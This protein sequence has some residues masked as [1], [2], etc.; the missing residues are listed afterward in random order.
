M[1]QMAN[2]L[3]ATT[4]WSHRVTVFLVAWFLYWSIFIYM[5]NDTKQQATKVQTLSFEWSNFYPSF[6]NGGCW[7]VS[8]VTSCRCDDRCCSLTQSFHTTRHPN[9][10]HQ[11]PRPLPIQRKKTMRTGDI[12]IRENLAMFSEDDLYDGW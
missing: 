5:Y 4:F 7:S 10:F 1:K 6:T 9:G 11:V 8:F 2:S 3:T 12:L